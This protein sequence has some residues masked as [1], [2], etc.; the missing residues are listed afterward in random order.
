MLN[1]IIVEHGRSIKLAKNVAGPSS[2]EIERL[3]YEV[4]RWER[5]HDAMRIERDH[6]KMLA[7]NWKERAEEK[8]TTIT[9]IWEALK[10][11][12]TF[13]NTLRK[14]QTLLK[15]HHGTRGGKL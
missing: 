4:S 15:R 13:F 11:K 9:A 12:D 6:F 1:T 7:F 8:D 3:E 10:E 14:I 2:S 5:F